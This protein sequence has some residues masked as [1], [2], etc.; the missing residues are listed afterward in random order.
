METIRVWSPQRG[1][2]RLRNGTTLEHY[3]KRFPQAIKVSCPTIAT[4]EK[5]SNDGIAKAVDGCRVE[6]DGTCPH[7][8]QSWMIVLGFI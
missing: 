6:P 1:L 3:Q 5:W 4:V 2:R 7:G 8:Y